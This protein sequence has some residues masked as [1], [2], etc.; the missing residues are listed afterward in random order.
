[1]TDVTSRQHRIPKRPNALIA[2]SAI[3]RHCCANRYIGM[4]GAFLVLF[5][6]VM[7]LCADLLPLARSAGAVGARS[8]QAGAV[9][10]PRRRHLLARHRRQGPRHPLAPDLRLAARAVLVDRSPPSSPMRSAC[11]MGVVAGYRGGWWDESPLLHRQRLS[12]LPADGSLPRASCRNF[13]PNSPSASAGSALG[14]SSTVGQGPHHRL[15]HHLRHRAAGGAHR[16]RPRPRP[17]D[18]RL[19]RGGRGAR[20]EARSTS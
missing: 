18:A 9:A 17:Q 16:A 8:A 11:C 6:I 14:F 2:D 19:Y 12:R 3:D 4:F 1:M 5:W 20:R 13:G 7:A 10:G 15:R